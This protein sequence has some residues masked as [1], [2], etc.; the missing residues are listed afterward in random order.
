MLRR[1]LEEAAAIPEAIE[2]MSFAALIRTA[3]EQDLLLGS[4][5]NWH[6][7]R[8]M[9]NITSHIYDEAKALKVIEAIPA[10]L[11]EARELLRRLQER[12]MS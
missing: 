5:A 10:F 7:Y 9:R 11:K 12:S 3:N 4:W 8:D 6:G 2:Q 1:Y